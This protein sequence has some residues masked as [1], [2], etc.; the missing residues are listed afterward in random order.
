P[1]VAGAAALL[2]ALLLFELGNLRIEKGGDLTFGLPIVLLGIAAA[3]AACAL[4]AVG[5]RAPVVGERA[6]FVLVAAYLV[7]AGFESARV[8]RRDLLTHRTYSRELAEEAAPLVATRPPEARCFR[9]P[10][11]DALSFRLFRSGLDWRDVKTPDDV[12]REASTVA[13][14]AYR[15]GAEP[16]P[17]AP[18]FRVRDWL[19][20]HAEDRTGA[21]DAR[22]RTTTGLRVYV[23]KA[24]P[25]PRA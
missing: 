14:W 22:A 15:E 8:I 1:L 18:S 17:E 13:I 19:A 9:A 5:V 12:A 21:V 23:P 6:P 7:F 20:A 10:E 24:P 11:P 3:T 25:P 2:S 4:L 16:G